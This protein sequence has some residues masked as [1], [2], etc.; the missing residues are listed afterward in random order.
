VKRVC[1]SN[2]KYFIFKTFH[3][4]LTHLHVGTK[5]RLTS[6]TNEVATCVI[7]YYSK[8]IMEMWLKVLK[9]DVY[10]THFK[11]GRFAGVTIAIFSE[12]ETTLELGTSHHRSKFSMFSPKLRP[13]PQL[14]SKP[15]ASKIVRSKVEKSLFL[16]VSTK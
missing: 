12:W 9:S 14:A 1:D 16:I 11:M 15:K 5:I 10:M 6:E 13:T 2:Q 8:M 3:T 4:S 7:Q